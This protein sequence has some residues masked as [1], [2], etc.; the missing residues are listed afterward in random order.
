[1]KEISA[2]HATHKETILKFSALVALLVGYFLWMSMKYDASTGFGL[3]LLTWSFFVLC[4]PVADGGFVIAFPVRLLFGV[5]MAVTQVVIWFV[6][7]G[8]NCV[9]LWKF[10]DS[11]SLTFL[12]S[13]LERILTVPYPY[14]SILLIISATGTLLSIYFGDEMMDVTSHRDREKHHTHGMKLKI[15]VTVGLGTLVV[16]AYYHLLSGLNIEMPE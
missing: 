2:K 15:L 11:Y 9:M 8:I 13:L 12:T 10:R 16:V 6:A 7:V 1:M 14:W 4:T 5:K 3:A